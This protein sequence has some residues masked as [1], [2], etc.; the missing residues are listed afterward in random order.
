MRQPFRV[1][2]NL[3]PPYTLTVGDPLDLK[4]EKLERRSIERRSSD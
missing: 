3:D 2:V 1:E 4:P